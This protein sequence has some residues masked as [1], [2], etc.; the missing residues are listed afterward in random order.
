[1]IR[2]GEIDQARVEG[3]ICV[4]P[5]PL[6]ADLESVSWNASAI[7]PPGSTT[8]VPKVM[9]KRRWWGKFADKAVLTD[10]D[11]RPPKCGGASTCCAVK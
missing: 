6:Q 5:A 10:R 1:M 7:P 11:D 8:P 9:L 2:E 3:A 4:D